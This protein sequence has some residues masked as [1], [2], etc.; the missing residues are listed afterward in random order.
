[1]RASEAYCEAYR[2]ASMYLNP[3]NATRLSVTLNYSV[4]LAESKKDL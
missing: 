2:I 4:F 1:M 3:C